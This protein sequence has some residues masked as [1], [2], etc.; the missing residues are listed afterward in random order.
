M[1]GVYI[2]REKVLGWQQD[3]AHFPWN[4]ESNTVTC[5]YIVNQ[6]LSI[7]IACVILKISYVGK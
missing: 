6:K 4:Y 3:R 5:E 2:I 7:L 1:P